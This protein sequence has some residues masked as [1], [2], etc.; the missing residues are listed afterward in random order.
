MKVIKLDAIDST[1]D[2]LKSMNQDQDIESYTVIV[3]NKQTKGK[4]QMGAV[5]YSEDYKNMTMS[6]LIKDSVPKVEDIFCLNIT[7]A[8]SIIQVLKK[9]KIVSLS[10]KWPNDIM[11]DSKK[12]GGILIENTIKEN[13]KIDSIIGIGLNVNQ[14]NFA[15]LPMASS[16]KNIMGYDFDLDK[17]TEEI[18]FK[19][20]ENID[21]LKK[22]NLDYF[23]EQYES[24][25]F[26]KGK[27]TLFEDIYRKRFMGI[28]DGVNKDGKIRLL[29]ENGTMNLYGIKEISMIF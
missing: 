19:I 4:G 1:N 10:I 2:F 22:N 21:T 17:L 29:L 3:A 16:I 26:K 14:T 9:L 7:V 5:W 12:I 6:V 11:A 25:L 27:P 13:G 15:G 20:K 24:I 23:W 18:V 28:I 8:L